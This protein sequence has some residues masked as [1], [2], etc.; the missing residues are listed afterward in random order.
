MS[1]ATPARINVPQLDECYEW[2]IRIDK[3][4]EDVMVAI[5]RIDR[6]GQDRVLVQ[7]PCGAEVVSW[8]NL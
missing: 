5:L 4:S 1:G 2:S 7:C 3:R 6:A 8:M